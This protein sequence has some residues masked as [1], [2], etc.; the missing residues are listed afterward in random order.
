MATYDSI[1][2]S[3]LSL[4]MVVQF[5]WR[6]PV[7]HFPASLLSLAMAVQFHWR[8]PVAL[9]PASFLSLAMVVPFHWRHPVQLFP[10]SFLS[11]AIF[12]S[13]LYGILS[14]IIGNFKSIPIVY[15]KI[16]REFIKL[17]QFIRI[18]YQ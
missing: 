13:F 14:M 4:A 6:H 17:T 12:F 8:H 9:F 7:P 15:R 2:F 1:A 16:F 5:H 18:D 3:F 10:A 11:L